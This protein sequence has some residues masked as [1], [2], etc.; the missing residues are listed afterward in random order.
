MIQRLW[1]KVAQR[2]KEGV[3]LEKIKEYTLTYTENRI[4]DTYKRLLSADFHYR[5][6]SRRVKTKEFEERFPLVD[7]RHYLVGNYYLDSQIP[8]GKEDIIYSFGVGGDIDFDLEVVSRFGCNVF[9]FD[10]QSYSAQF[11]KTNHSNNPKLKYSQIGVW[12]E[13]GKFRFEIDRITGQASLVWT[14]GKNNAFEAYCKPITQIMS[15]N[16][17]LSIDVLKMDIEGAAIEVLNQVLDADVFP[18]QIIVEFERPRYSTK[19]TYHFFEQV[20]HL[21]SRMRD[22]GYHVA[23]LPRSRASYFSVELLFSRP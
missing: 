18:T 14:N 20:E 7:E 22:A 1:K 9:L 15:D 21:A 13:E 12:K 23:R 4:K 5:L 2:H 19:G 8:I 17:H 10:P 3:L 11:M 6:D 16:G